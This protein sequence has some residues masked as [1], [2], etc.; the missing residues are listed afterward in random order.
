M[1]KQFGVD[2]IADFN[3]FAHRLAFEGKHYKYV[4][5]RV[6][7]SLAVSMGS[8]QEDFVRIKRTRYL[9]G[10]FSYFSHFNHTA[11][12]RLLATTGEILKVL[13]AGE[14]CKVFQTK[15]NQ[16]LFRGAVHH[17][18]ADC[19]FPSPGDDEA[20]VEQRLD[21]R[22]R[23][24]AANLKN[25]RHGDWLFVGDDSEGF[26]RGQRKFCAGF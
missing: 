12:P 26:E 6:A 13:Y 4:N 17:R 23:L 25:L 20:L 24:N 21:G 1:K 9:R 15:L 14:F 7:T 5:I 18:P 11:T 8:E 3:C 16:K 10:E 19:L 22:R 2:S